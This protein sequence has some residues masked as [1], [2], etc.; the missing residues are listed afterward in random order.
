[1]LLA[2]CR[3][4]QPGPNLFAQ[5]A[6]APVPSVPLPQVQTGE[7]S[8]RAH[9]A[10]GDGAALE[11]AYINAAVKECAVRGGGTVVVEA[12]TYLTG[13]VRL[14]DNITLKLEAGAKLLG[15]A[16]LAD[17]PPIQRASEDRNTALIVAENVHHVAVIGTGTI[18]GNGRAFAEKA[19]PHFDPYFEPAQTR[20]GTALVSRLAETREGPVHMRARPGVLLLILHSDGIILRD[21][22]VVDSPNWGVKLMCSRHISVSG[23]DVRNDVL[24]PNNDALDISTS[25][26][27]TISNSTLEAG[28]DALVIGGPCADGWCQEPEE[29][30]VVSN[31]VLSSRSTALRI[32]PAAKDVRNLTF[33]NIVIRDSNRG[34]CIQARAGET[35]ENLLFTNIVSHTRLIDGPWWGSGEPI[36]MSVARW[37]YPPWPAAQSAGVIRHVRFNNIIAESQSPIVLYSTA[38]GGI[39]DVGFRDLTLTMQATPLQS[40]MGGNIDLQPTTP[41]SQGVIRHDLSAIEAHNVRDLTLTSLDVHWAGTFPAFYRGALHADH[42]DGLTVDGFRGRAAADGVPA[43]AFDHGKN[44]AIYRAHA[45][46]GPLLAPGVTGSKPKASPTVSAAKK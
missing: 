24:I 45:E 15:S 7:C 10:K 42:Y 13:T 43:L 28:D 44:L 32:G 21:F 9:G 36:S 34:I 22:S 46:N 8:V 12:G 14:L 38:S 2:I 5:D 18:D 23:L 20:Q 40:V 17:Y 27:V 33:E 39:E 35:I 11:T 1:L 3:L 4:I 19:S 26:D 37:A 16:D 6:A 25:S 41:I 31:V 30:V 29:N